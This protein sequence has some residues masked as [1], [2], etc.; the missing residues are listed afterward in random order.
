MTA[1]KLSFLAFLM[2]SSSVLAA[3]GVSLAQSTLDEVVV[4]ATRREERLQD[5]PVA[6]TAISGTAL[7]RQKIQSVR[8]L[9]RVVP[10][11][12][13]RP[14]PGDNTSASITMRGL[15]TG[16]NL[17]SVDPT[18]GTYLDGVYL[19]RATVSNLGMLDV[20]RVDVAIEEVG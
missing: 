9:Q 10:S 12:T 6:V 11:L 8:D 1:K 4:T 17:I 2:L 15:G 3:P 7:E 19:G 5:I 16:D 14:F 18:V 20:A 13:I